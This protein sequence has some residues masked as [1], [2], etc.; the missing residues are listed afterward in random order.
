LP[1]GDVKFALGYE[2][3][4]E[5]QSFDPGAFYRGELQSD[6]SYVQYGNSTPITP[7]SG[8]YHTDEGFGEL[9]VPLVNPDMPLASHP[10]WR[11]AASLTQKRPGK[12]HPYNCFYD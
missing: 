9:T 11:G 3:R 12:L 4:R 2:H 6:G 8:A 10:D 5:S 7:V 1:A